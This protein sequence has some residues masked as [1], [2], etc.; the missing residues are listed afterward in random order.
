MG[1]FLSADSLAPL[2]FTAAV[3]IPSRVVALALTPAQRTQEHSCAKYCI[4]HP[5]RKANQAAEVEKS[6]LVAISLPKQ[7]SKA[8]QLIAFQ[9][10]LFLKAVAGILY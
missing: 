6:Y 3:T 2:Q 7:L 1:T 10:D 5:K 4:S 8:S 9:W